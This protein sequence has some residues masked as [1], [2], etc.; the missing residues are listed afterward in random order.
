MSSSVTL[1]DDCLGVVTS[2]ALKC[3]ISSWI[4]NSSIGLTGLFK[5]PKSTSVPLHPEMGT[6]SN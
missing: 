5:G 6:D 4:R 3:L 1:P 2:I